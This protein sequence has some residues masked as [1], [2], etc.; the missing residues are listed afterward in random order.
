MAFFV[1]G[2]ISQKKEA[3]VILNECGWEAKGYDSS[4]SKFRSAF[5]FCAFVLFGSAFLFKFHFFIFS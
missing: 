2:L 3:V 1:L 4:I 5:E